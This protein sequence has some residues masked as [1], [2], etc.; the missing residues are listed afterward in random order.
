MNNEVPNFFGNPKKDSAEV[1]YCP[2]CGSEMKSDARYCMK[3]GNLN[4]N[5][6]ANQSMKNIMGD[7]VVNQATTYQVGATGVVSNVPKKGVKTA[8]ASDTGSD[9]F[10][11]LINYLLYVICLAVIIL[12]NMSKDITL[13][14]LASFKIAIPVT[15]ISLFFL[16]F[17]SCE[18]IF[19]KCNKRW[20]KS[21]IPI[22]NLFLL[23][24]I[25]HGKKKYAI[26][27]FIPIVG[28]I[29]WLS[30]LY[31]L[32]TRFRFNGILMVLFF[33]IGIPYIALSSSMYDDTLYVSGSN[34]SL[35]VSY[36]RR[37]V[38]IMTTILFF[39]LSIGAF[40][41][42]NQAEIR[43]IKRLIANTY[44]VYTAKVITNKVKTKI[45]HN[46]YNCDS[47]DI[48][49]STEGSYYFNFPDVGRKV[50][51]LFYHNRDAIEGYVRVEIVKVSEKK[52]RKNYYIS[53]SD[54]TYGFSE[55]NIKDLSLEDVV[56]YDH[57]DTSFLDQGV[58]LCEFG[59]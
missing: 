31:K 21:F 40:L 13:S 49:T 36:G 15:I 11:F 29:F 19:M 12:P 26:L 14:E 30:V 18:L 54:G 38:F 46:F 59:T 6:E 7:E 33:P 25:T 47:N 5:H 39:V 52:V 56:K 24:E 20:W 51:L 34:K 17:Y 53:I 4:Y 41:Y 28:Q 23:T 50:A 10:C 48:Y 57:V 9:L 44:Y 2:R 37:K 45:N 22:Y 16:Y 55:V 8:L 35:E 58:R 42:N 43:H 1:I 27:F 3:C 32:G